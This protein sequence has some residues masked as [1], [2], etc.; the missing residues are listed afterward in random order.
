M[1]SRVPALFPATIQISFN[2]W[3]SIKMQKK[4]KN[5]SHTVCPLSLNPHV[6]GSAASAWYPS[7]KHAIP[8]HNQTQNTRGEIRSYCDF[9]AHI[10]Y[11]HAHEPCQLIHVSICLR[12]RKT[13]DTEQER[14]PDRAFHLIT[15]CCKRTYV[16]IHIKL[17]ICSY[18]LLLVCVMFSPTCPSVQVWSNSVPH[19][20]RNLN[21]PHQTCL[22]GTYPSIWK[23]QQQTLATWNVFAKKFDTFADLMQR[24]FWIEL[25]FSNVHLSY[26]W[27]IQQRW[28]AGRRDMRFLASVSPRLCVAGGDANRS[29]VA[30]EEDAASERSQWDTDANEALA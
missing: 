29:S 8:R 17:C 26:Y 5:P 1:K 13:K 18:F 4:K 21:K 6:S 10:L 9:D 15:S 23:R 19:V 20:L 11:S 16:N 3:K 22:M 25:F 2:S 14:D 7:F 30:V 27:W 12:A 28:I 24:Y